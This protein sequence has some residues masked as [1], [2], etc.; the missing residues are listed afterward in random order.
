MS[1][2]STQSKKSATSSQESRS[3]T[4]V[5]SSIGSPYPQAGIRVTQDL[6]TRITQGGD[7]RIRS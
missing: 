4:G 1:T 2:T 3:A 6:N 5:Y 7:R